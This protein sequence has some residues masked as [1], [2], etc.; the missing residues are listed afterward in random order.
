MTYPSPL[1]ILRHGETVWNAQ[2]RLQ[3]HADSP[4]TPTG[5][6]QAARQRALLAQA[7]AAHLPLRSSPS[8]RALTTAEIARPGRPIL[9]DARLMEVGLGDWTGQAITDIAAAN[10]H[11]AEDGDPHMWKF[12]APGGE[13]L[14][15]LAA[16]CRAVLD[17]LDGPTI[18]VTHGLTSRVL[19]C[20]ALGLSPDRMMD[21]PGG[22]GVIHHIA[23]GAAR[24]MA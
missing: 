19:R 23:D 5:R 7:G 10:P 1:F 18:L 21:L 8:P 14:G 6:D 20:L 24:L 22:Q 11:V 15:D 3:G 12:T 17:D 4:L 2:G 16:R 9:L 13:R